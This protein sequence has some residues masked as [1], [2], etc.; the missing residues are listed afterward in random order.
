MRPAVAQQQAFAFE[1]TKSARTTDHA[2]PHQGGRLALASR[3]EGESLPPSPHGRRQHS[4][5]GFKMPVFSKLEQDINE[6]LPTLRLGLDIGEWAGGIAIVRNASVLHGETYTDYHNTTLE[7]RRGVRR[8]RRTRRAKKMRLARLRSWTTR[9]PDPS[10]SAEIS[11]WRA[12]HGEG[13]GI[14]KHLRLPDPYRLMAVHRF[15]CQPGEYDAGKKQL[16]AKAGKAKDALGTW[17]EEVKLGHVVDSEAFVVALTHLF[18]KRGFAWTGSDLA[19]MTDKEL[20]EEIRKVRLTQA[21]ADRVRA[22]IERRKHNPEPEREGKIADIEKEIEL[23]LKRPKQ[24]RVAEHREIVASE[25]REVVSAFVRAHGGEEATVIAR[26]WSSALVKILN[27]T[28]RPARFENRV[29]SGCSWCGK[30][31]PRKYKVREYAFKAALRNVRARPVGSVAGLPL[32]D[33]QRCDFLRVLGDADFRV[34]TRAARQDRFDRMLRSLQ[35]QAEMAKQLAELTGNDKPGG[36]TNLC[37]QHLIR[38]SDGAFF[39]SRHRAICTL[40][41]D[42]V[43]HKRLESITRYGPAVRS[44]RNPCREAHDRRLIQRVEQ[45]VFD[46]RGTH[47]TAASRP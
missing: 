34:K 47:V 8:G 35:G 3:D 10:K 7:D 40:E 36:R 30:N 9:Q 19:E 15:Q 20:A 24:P 13:R 25:L 28:I 46:R 21:V 33:P 6:F 31:T 37:K 29:N 5:R 45:V 42:G 12:A 43:N 17:V 23:A 41:A 1:W 2:A 27:K 4:S 14:P 32:S 38:A 11:A 26:T 18:Q 16:R 39:C 22:E 44:T